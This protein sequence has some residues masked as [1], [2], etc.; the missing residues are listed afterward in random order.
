VLPEGI[1]V[2]HERNQIAADLPPVEGSVALRVPAVEESLRTRV[3]KDDFAELRDPLVYA[4]R[5]A[6]VKQRIDA[7][8]HGVVAVLAGSVR[9]DVAVVN[10]IIGIGEFAEQEK[11]ALAERVG[12]LAD[13]RAEPGAGQFAHV[14]HRI[15]AKAVYVGLADPVAM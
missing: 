4:R 13:P 9:A 8:E 2:V 6:E 14:L 7:E 1:V 15:H 11:P 10:R 3:A 12:V 5:Q